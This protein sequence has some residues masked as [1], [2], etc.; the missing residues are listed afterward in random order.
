[1]IPRSLEEWQAIRARGKSQYILR[2]GVLGRGLPLGVLCAVALEMALGHELPD[3]L[4]TAGF[5]G[6]LLLAVSVFSI[7]GSLSARMTWNIHERRF[8][9][10]S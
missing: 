8:S 7:S 2:N 1:M 10:K 5:A 9:G 3:A 6:R 4:A